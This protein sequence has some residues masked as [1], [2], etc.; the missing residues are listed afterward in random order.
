MSGRASCLIGI[1]LGGT[2]VKFGLLDTEGRVLA[3]CSLPTEAERG[4]DQAL[5]TFEAGVSQLLADAGR[6]RDD[7]LSVGIGSPGPLSHSEGKLHDPGNLPGWKGFPLRDRLAKRLGRPVALDNDAN[8]AALGEFWKGAGQGV[9]DMVLFTLGTGVGSGI[10][11]DGLVFHGRFENGAELGHTIVV[12]GGRPCSCGQRGCLEAY[13][14]ATA[15]VDQAVEAARREP[16]SKLRAMLEARGSLTAEDLEAT[17]RE[18]DAAAEAVWDI[19]CHMLAVA[20]VN[21]Q[22]GFNVELIVLGGGMSGA[23]ELLLS[24][25]QRHFDRE[26]W[27]LAED[28]PRIVLAGLG[29]DAGMMGAARMALQMLTASA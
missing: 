8:M 27:K 28:Y 13:S 11:L 12:P 20:C 4:P 17:C 9:R 16:E 23:G 29:N 6:R 22:H 14:S 3:K 7:L 1:D 15:A 24:C 26:T 21:V 18:G 2:A 25:V 5:E 19:V 10:I